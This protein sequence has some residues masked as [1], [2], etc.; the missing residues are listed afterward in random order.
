MANTRPFLGIIAALPAEAR[1]AGVRHAPAGEVVRIADDVLLIRCGIG[2]TRATRAA[3]S[4]MDAGAGALLSWGTAAALDR[5]LGLGD[6]VL[7]RE[8]LSREGHRFSTDSRWRDR[9]CGILE[10]GSGC[11]AG[12]VAEADSVLESADDKLLLHTLSGALIA[13]MESAAIAEVCQGTGC[14]LLVVRAVS[15]RVATRIP[16]CALAAVD[17]NGDVKLARCLGSLLL[18]PGDLPALLRLARGFRAACAALS[19]LA[20]RAGPAFLLSAPERGADS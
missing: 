16:D 12:T 5:Q 7:P 4:L 17:A 20:Q 1:A 15:D 3:E 8:V 10:N 18:A 9:L 6:L 14:S 13:D 11:H 2:R 19:R